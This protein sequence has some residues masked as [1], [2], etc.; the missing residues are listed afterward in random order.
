VLG[1]DPERTVCNFWK[2]VQK[3]ETHE[4]WL[5][6]GSL[7][8]GGYGSFAIDRKTKSASRVS[9]MIHHGPIPKGMHVLHNCPDGD[10][11]RCVNPAH[12]Y[13]GT[14]VEN[15]RDRAVKKQCA[16]GER[17][18]WRTHPEAMNPPR[19]DNHW[20]RRRPEL[21]PRGERKGSARLTEIEVRE[22]RRLAEE[23][24]TQRKL[25]TR[26]NVTHPCICDVINR[27]TWRHVK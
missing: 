13:L 25:A 1:K 23:G 2:K 5:W 24:W 7:K 10:N 16:S 4:C 3:R 8:S 6:I 17:H 14:Q 18:G 11:K 12:L 21:V 19:G 22:I 26:F 15:G 9:W 20:S 27:K